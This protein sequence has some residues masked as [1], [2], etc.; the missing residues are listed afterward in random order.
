MVEGVPPQETVISLNQ[1]ARAL[2]ITHGMSKVQAEAAGRVF[3]RS[4][5]IAGEGIVFTRVFEIAARFSPRVEA[6]SAPANAYGGGC[7]LSVLLLLDG[8]G[9]GTL[10]GSAE[11][12]A[13]RLYQEMRVAGFPASVGTAPNTE[14]ALLLARACRR[15]VSADHNNLP[16]KL[17][18]LPTAL[19]PCEL[20]ILAVLARWGIRTL[21]ELA[22]LP[23]TALIS[24]LGQ[25]GRHLQQLALGEA[26]RLL[27][28]EEPEFTPSATTALDGPCGTARFAAL[29]ACA[30][31]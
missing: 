11:S 1:S 30:P 4:R 23:E 7:N 3:C 29:R 27:V 21:G 28:P 13:R 18:P 14:A 20:R 22:S 31:A 12:Y 19:L 25:Q 10:F 6:I 2:A 17:A 24:R 9:T 26:G 16:Q 15:V 8:A 5:E